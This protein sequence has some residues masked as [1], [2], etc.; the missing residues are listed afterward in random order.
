MRTILRE[1]STRVMLTVTAVLVA[2]GSLAAVVMNEVELARQA[3]GMNLLPTWV[4]ALVV[5]VCTG[6]ALL[7]AHPWARSLAD[8]TSETVAVPL[9]RLAHRTDEMASGGFALDPQARPGRLV[10]PGPWHSGILEVDAL[11]REIDRH[12]QTFARALVFERSFAADASHQ[13]RTPLAALLLR[14][15]EIAQSDDPA[16]A[17]AEADIAIA[18]VERLTGVVDELL[19]R[20]RA[21]HA[22]GG[23]VSAVDTVLA[24]IDKEWT[25]AFEEAGRTIRLTCERGVIVEASSSALSQVLNTLVENALIHGAGQVDVHVARSGPSA[26]VTVGDHGPGVPRELSRAIFDRGRTTGDGTGLGL[27]VARET[28]EAIGGRLELVQ[29]RPAVFSCYLPL[30]ETS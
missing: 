24:G 3:A 10:D 20:T 4:T 29:A 6:V 25:P 7:I 12:H 13:L 9:R 8:R 19:R 11:A 26:V 23:A 21:G 27:A 22:S 17:R 15:E 1:H 28:V 14:L 5:L 2:V 30:A 16:V 18:Q